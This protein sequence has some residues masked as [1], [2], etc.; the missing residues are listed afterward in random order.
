MVE[1]MGDTGID[2]EVD[3]SEGLLERS[4]AL[5]S[6]TA[7]LAAVQA[8]G[9]RVVFIAGE[10]GIGK[11][12][13]LRAFRARHGARPRFFWGACDPLFT[14][15]P[16]GPFADIAQPAGGEFEA[17]VEEGAKPY[18]IASALLRELARRPTVL[19]LEDVHWADEASLDVLRM[20][21][22]RIA[23]V[24]A[25]VLAS[26]R[27]DELR[28]DHAFRGV[29][30]ELVRG[31][32]VRRM[33]LD[34][35]SAAAVARMAES[36]AVDA[37]ELY[38][39]TGGNAFFV[40]EVLAAGKE[41][42]PQTVRDAIMARV[43]RLPTAARSLLDAAAISSRPTEL[44]LLELLAP[45]EIDALDACLAS[46]VLNADPEAV[47]FRHE[48]ARLAIDDAIPSRRR[49]KLHREALEA[50][51]ERDS[52]DLARLAH[53]ADAA[54]DANAVRRY[55]PAAG[56]RAAAL[57][58]HREAAAQ[59]ERA[60]RYADELPPEGQADLLDRTAEE[61]RLVGRATDA[62]EFRRR[63]ARIY[64][65]TGDRVRE[66]DSLRAQAWP[67]W[68][69]GRTQEAEAAGRD[70]I[71]VLEAAGGG[72]ELA[73][74]Y[75]G[76][77]LLAATGGDRAGGAV[78]GRRAIEL[79]EDL[80]ETQPI[81]EALAH[82]GAVEVEHNEAVGEELLTR[83]LE[84]S[85]EH[86]HPA[87]AA[88]ALVYLARAAGR[89]WRFEEAERWIETAIE[90]CNRYDLEGSS[91]Y[92]FMTRAECELERGEWASAENSVA[93]VLRA[94]GI[95]PATVGALAVLGHL[96]ARR[97]DG[98]HW[99]TLD[100]ALELAAPASQLPRLGP[101]AVARAEAAWIDGRNDAA[102]AETDRV[103][104]LSLERGSPWMTGELALWRRLAGSDEAPR[105]ELAEP[106]ERALAGDWREACRLWAELGCR[107]HWALTAADGDDE[108]RRQALESLHSMGA[109]AAAKA[110]MRRMRETGAR[111][112]P[113]GPRPQTS[114]NPAQL[115]GREMEVLGLLAEGLRNAEIAERLVVS[116]RTVD[117]HVSAIL[118]KLDVGSRAQAVAAATDLGLT[119]PT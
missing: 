53:H 2:L 52:A 97:G 108:H 98:S 118:R 47:T 92:L 99:E 51:S 12:S 17:L 19:V 44:W 8:D 105:V 24:P 10:A 111:N 70:A 90:H 83:S 46:G 30:G 71:A 82:M 101:V 100:R 95:G 25:L 102:L 5:D 94:G 61:C 119:R 56:E 104:E 96:R 75:A 36:H 79:A 84:L 59:Y 91:P 27:D 80:G 73:R 26:Y 55:A 78:W 35:L 38:E 85:R 76:M 11:T 43:S 114:R 29:L 32:S 6:L 57:G 117:H 109:H 18:E 58:A 16:L 87:E 62:I 107:Y 106:Y 31:R 81:V 86:G 4:A 13:L 28:S 110:V 45:A 34:L 33:S 116:V 42:I 60:L 65:K 72:I 115:T 64:S 37:E 49:A 112:V 67:L 22:S 69:I 41:E 20:V 103:W 3:R 66:G 14:P 23:D 77:A 113:R 7:D 68:L 21:T 9:G 93:L 39:T 15:R 40:T 48:L 50:L 88:F 74:A 63:A 89:R 1:G 54:R